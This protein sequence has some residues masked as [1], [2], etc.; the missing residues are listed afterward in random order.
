[1]RRTRTSRD[2]EE[3]VLVEP[4]GILTRIIMKCRNGICIS[5]K[6]NMEIAWCL[7]NRSCVQSRRPA[8]PLRHSFH[9]PNRRQP[10][11]IPESS[12]TCVTFPMSVC[13]IY[14]PRNPHTSPPSLLSIPQLCIHAAKPQRFSL[15]ATHMRRICICAASH[16]HR[17]V[18]QLVIREN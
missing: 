3:K 9:K 15:N 12:N 11:I 10:T 18:E 1:M 14:F 7:V 2:A 4:W 17:C 6:L 13:K 16:T 5:C 8:T